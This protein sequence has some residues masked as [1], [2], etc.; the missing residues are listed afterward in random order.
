MRLL[1]TNAGRRTYMVQYALDLAES[2]LDMEVFVSDCVRDVA[3]FHV[4]PKVHTLLLPP[5]LAD[6]DAYSAALVA[7]LRNN[8]IDLVFPLS[9]LDLDVLA[10]LQ[11]MLAKEGIRAVIAP[12]EYSR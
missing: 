2:A 7:A 11:P 8:R 3:A 1:F 5:A 6:R 9:D 10:E 4:S 12:P